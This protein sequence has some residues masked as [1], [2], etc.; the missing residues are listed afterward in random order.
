MVT[1]TKLESNTKIK[2]IFDFMNLCKNIIK[3]LH[4]K[5]L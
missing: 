3:Q 2:I 5:V 1:D 4:P